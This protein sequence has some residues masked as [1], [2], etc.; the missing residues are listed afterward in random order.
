M[1]GYGANGFMQGFMEGIGPGQQLA[2]AVAQRRAASR[3]NAVQDQIDSGQLDPKTAAGQQ[4]IQTAIRNAQQPLSDR[5][6]DPTYGGAQYDRLRGQGVLRANQQAGDQANAG[7]LSGGL[8]TSAKGMFAAGDIAGGVQQQGFGDQVYAGE[9]SIDSQ[10]NVDPEA[11]ARGVSRAAAMNGNPA[12]ALQMEG[13]QKTEHF[14][15]LAGMGGNI[16]LRM[17][18]TPLD[19]MGGYI[20]PM[21][22]LAGLG[23]VQW[24]PSEQ[25]WIADDGQGHRTAT[26]NQQTLE[27]FATHWSQNPENIP[28]IVN[29][30]RAKQADQQAQLG[31]YAAQ[32][33]IAAGYDVAKQP[34]ERPITASMRTMAAQA[35]GAA[36][37]AGWKIETGTKATNDA[38]PG[39]STYVVQ[40]PNGEPL[41][42]TVDVTHPE[43][44]VTTITTAE[45][46]PLPPTALANMGQGAALAQHAAEQQAYIDAHNASLANRQ[47]QISGVVD[48]GRHVSGMLQPTG[49]LDSALSHGAMGG[50]GAKGEAVIHHATQASPYKSPYSKLNSAQFMQESGGNPSALSPKGARGLAQ[51]MPDTAR[52]VEQH[53]GMAPGQ[54][55]RDPVANL[56]AGMAYRDHLI[57]SYRAQGMDP[58]HAVALGL[59][60]YNAGPGRVQAY[61]QGKS[62]LPAETKQYVARIMNSMGSGVMT[63]GQGA[64]P[65]PPAQ[66][67][68][69]QPPQ[70]NAGGV[71]LTNPFAA[72]RQTS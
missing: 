7:D 67:A 43:G 6:L 23:D 32:Q 66:A 29:A 54:T 63:G 72:V 20:A 69:A 5:G 39:K 9:H 57:E 8:Q 68:P 25:A 44:P 41:N 4:A 21:A 19:Q 60:A 27:E 36:Q 35:M 47:S 70:I 10:G 58:T 56:T 15:S 16:L 71:V 62:D 26:I 53:L 49:G 12:G 45:G 42:M 52:A 38:T 1:S 14:N 64:P 55:D 24:S 3:M 11:L 17:K 59:A 22:K 48:W 51:L 18:D 34:F 31:T 65:A 13:V 28:A 30:F 61:L 40:G 50:K 37:K 33:N 46:Q 2:D